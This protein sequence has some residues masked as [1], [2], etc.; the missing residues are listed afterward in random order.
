MKLN[1]ICTFNVL[2][3]LI[4]SF[5]SIAQQETI[6]RD[7]SSRS[8]Y[9]RVS[10]YPNASFS[11]RKNLCGVVFPNPLWNPTIYFPEDFQN[12]F[13]SVY[14]RNNRQVDFTLSEVWIYKD[15]K[16]TAKWQTYH[17]NGQLGHITNYIRQELDTIILIDSIH[18][19]P[20][21]S[22]E[23]ID[24]LDEEDWNVDTPVYIILDEKD[25]KRDTIYQYEGLRTAFNCW[26]E[27][28]S[29]SFIQTFKNGLPHGE[30]LLY[31]ANGQLEMKIDYF[32]GYKEGGE[33]HWNENGILIKH[34]QYK[35]D[36]LFGWQK[37]YDDNGKLIKK[38]YYLNG[39]L[40]KVKEMK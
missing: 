18:Y 6:Y 22:I 28:G 4:L 23:N 2:I 30:T 21:E 14:R 33:K 10:N 37:Y 40:E 36:K 19:L 12:G 13:D 8:T 38:E 11:E 3:C 31:H 34:F 39:K 9:L 5:S 26:H 27:N 7:T 35:E 15:N 16:G 25:W 24:T 1:F 32:N 29:P 17:K 20:D